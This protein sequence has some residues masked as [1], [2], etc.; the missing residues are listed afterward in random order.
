MG[1]KNESIT[2]AS[3]K[4]SFKYMVEVS[5]WSSTGINKYETGVFSDNFKLGVLLLYKNENNGNK[6]TSNI[7]LKVVIK[8]EMKL[9]SVS[10]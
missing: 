6:H 8:A 9:F 7:I 5:D 2:D 3:G 4:K 1:T 10:P